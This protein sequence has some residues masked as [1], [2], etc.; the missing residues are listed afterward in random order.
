MKDVSYAGNHFTHIS[1]RH[2]HLFIGND[3]VIFFQH[4]TNLYKYLLSTVHQMLG[5]N[6]YSIFTIC[7]PIL[8]AS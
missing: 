1:V 5:E 4:Q 7:M 8:C 3:L 2:Q 6:P